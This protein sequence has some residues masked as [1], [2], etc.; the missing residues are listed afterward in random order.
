MF[1]NKELE[2]N[3]TQKR[4]I[5]YSLIGRLIWSLDDDER[6]ENSVLI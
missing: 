1:Q 4:R 3:F 6:I 2:E 5:V